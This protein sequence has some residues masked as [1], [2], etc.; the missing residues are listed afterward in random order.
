MGWGPFPN[1]PDNHAAKDAEAIK[2]CI[3]RNEHMAINQWK[4]SNSASGLNLNP[5]QPGG[6]MRPRLSGGT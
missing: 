2:D 6:G 5:V 1:M 4:S 3:R